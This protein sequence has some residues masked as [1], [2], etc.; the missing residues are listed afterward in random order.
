V[1]SR[2]G[3]DKSRLGLEPVHH[4]IEC[5]TVVQVHVGRAVR[6]PLVRAPGLRLVGEREVAV[7]AIRVVAIG[8]RGISPI[9]VRRSPAIPSRSEA[10]TTGLPTYAR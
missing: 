5:P 8:I 6:E 3:C 2:R 10:C 7:V 4:Q 9:R 1:S